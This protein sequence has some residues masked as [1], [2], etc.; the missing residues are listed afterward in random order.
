M[1]LHLICARFSE[2]GAGDEIL[3]AWD[4]W[5]LD[6][7]EDGFEEKLQALKG[8]Y[9]KADIRVAIVE[10]PD[11]FFDNVFKATRVKGKLESTE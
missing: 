11:E 7:N 2:D 6:G 1:D 10:V 5:T 4:E 3:D 8:E 9:P